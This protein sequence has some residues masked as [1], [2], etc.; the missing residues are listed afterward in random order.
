[1]LTATYT[2]TR[3]FGE[4]QVEPVEFA[5]AKLLLDWEERRVHVD[6]KTRKEG[7]QRIMAV[8]LAVKRLTDRVYE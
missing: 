2:Y 3:Y 8:T 1:M 4:D 7:D 6:W 5:V